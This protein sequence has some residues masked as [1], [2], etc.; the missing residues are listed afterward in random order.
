[1]TNRRLYSRQGLF[2][3]NQKRAGPRLNNKIRRANTL[4]LVLRPTLGH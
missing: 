1:M 2:E 4:L 3:L